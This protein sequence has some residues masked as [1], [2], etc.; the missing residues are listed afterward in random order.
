MSRKKRVPDE[1]AE[2]SQAISEAIARSKE[3]Q[4]ALNHL[5]E[6]NLLG[7]QNLI[8]LVLQIEISSIE[9]EVSQGENA[10]RL[11]PP[12]RRVYQVDGRKL[13]AKEIAFEDYFARHFNEQEWLKKWHLRLDSPSE[14]RPP[15][16]ESNA[17]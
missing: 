10:R 1:F 13:S 8:S 2:L 11:S 3:V 12:G 15:F 5:H 14:E 4:E 16:S 9:K 7:A 6:K 17:P